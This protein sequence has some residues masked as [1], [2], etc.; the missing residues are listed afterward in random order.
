ML[1]IFIKKNTVLLTSHTILLINRKANRLNERALRIVYSNYVS[2]FQ[3]LINTDNLF[4]ID[5]QYIQS[6]ASEI[7]K[8]LNKLAGEPLKVSL[9]KKQTV[10]LSALYSIRNLLQSTSWNVFKSALLIFVISFKVPREKHFQIKRC[11]KE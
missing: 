5:H 6:L 10:I 4:I 2:F 11:Q 8:T 3:D 7:F 1:I 9:V